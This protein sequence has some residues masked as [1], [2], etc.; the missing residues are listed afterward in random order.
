MA[1]LRE[2]RRHLPG[3]SL[4][5]SIEPVSDIDLAVRSA[6]VVLAAVPAQALR[7]VLQSLATSLQPGVTVVVCAKGIERKTGRFMSDVVRDCLPGNPPAILSGPSFAGDVGRG[8]PT[9]VTIAAETLG[10]AAQ[11]GARLGSASFRLYHT[12]DIRGVEIGGAVKNVLAIACG[13]AEGRGLGASACA[14]LI[15]RAFAEMSR[16]GQRAGGRTETL[17]GLSGL[18][19]LVLTCSSVQSRNF[20][21]GRAIGLKTLPANFTSGSVVEGV[22]TAQVL[23]DIAQSHH[24]DMPIATSVAAVLAGTLKVEEAIDGLLSRPF[25]AEHSIG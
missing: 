3:L 8:L 2:N 21:F 16:F 20:A 22:W 18:G 10:E 5:P 9:A 19:D 24:I 11:L 7:Q 23:A 25:R 12:D 13:I 15:A 1:S 17:A 6:D 4:D 14:A